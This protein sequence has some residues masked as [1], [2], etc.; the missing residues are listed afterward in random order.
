VLFNRGKRPCSIGRY[1][2]LQEDIREG[3]DLENETKQRSCYCRA[4]CAHHDDVP[5]FTETSIKQ[6][7]NFLTERFLFNRGKRPR[8]Y[9]RVHTITGGYQEIRGRKET[10]RVVTLCVRRV[11]PPHTIAALFAALSNSRMHS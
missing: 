9:W 3:S 7:S 4:V 8:S 1:I 5:A 2:L 11:L 6:Y 10:S